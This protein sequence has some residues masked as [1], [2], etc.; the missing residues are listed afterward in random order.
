MKPTDDEDRRSDGSAVSE[1]D[2]GSSDRRSNGISPSEARRGTSALR[3][4]GGRADATLDVFTST[5]N[6]R[7]PTTGERLRRT[8]VQSIYAPV[9]VAWS[10][11]RTRVGLLLIG[12][13]L[14]VGTVGVWVTPT[15]T[16]LG[17]PP[18]TAPFHDGWITFP[19]T[20]VGPLSIPLPQLNSFLGTD[21]LGRDMFQT[22]VHGTPAMIKMVAAGA[23]FS[24]IVGTLIGSI[25]GYKGGKVDYA[26]M[27]VTDVV[28][29]I[30]GL[31][32]VIVIA[33]IWTPKS[34][35]IVGLIL[36]ID[37]WPGLS[38]N[39][40]SQVLSLR[41]EAYT[42]ASRAMGLSKSTILRKDVITNMMPYI[43]VN[44]ANGSR[45]IIFESVALYFLG[46]LPYAS[47]N[48][49]V[50]MDAAYNSGDI[51]DPG[52]VH[53]LLLP[54]FAIILVS[55]GFLLFAQGTDR[56]FNVRLR[57]KHAQKDSPEDTTVSEPN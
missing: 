55:L 4:D 16:M 25:A 7:E 10:D 22:L 27:T 30:P 15:T 48:W 21:N 38:R 19:S 24:V 3:S 36:G 31:V 40:R 52:K 12:I 2:E 18:F 28:L 51:T 34:P 44:L 54:M 37:N 33:A 49:G 50:M 5:A 56:V 42:E 43:L 14:L 26:L 32:L 23:I 45:K 17:A 47:E 35:Y 8:F 9:A 11:I 20:Q 57:A 6:V 39:L 13:F 41:E 53:W 29:T 46:I 1:A